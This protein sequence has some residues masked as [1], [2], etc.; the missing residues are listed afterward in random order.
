MRHFD[1]AFLF[2]F[3]MFWSIFFKTGFLNSLIVHS[4]SCF[5]VYSM[6]I[7]WTV[8]QDLSCYVF[9]FRHHHFVTTIWRHNHFKPA[10]CSFVHAFST[11]LRVWR[12]FSL[13]MERV[14]LFI[15]VIVFGHTSLTLLSKLTSSHWNRIFFTLIQRYIVKWLYITLIEGY[16]RATSR[17]SNRLFLIKI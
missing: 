8:R 15:W 9:L 10:F 3:L 11:E 4:R 17:N 14:F 16:L 1:V 2:F 12:H 6:K 5:S 7:L 13:L